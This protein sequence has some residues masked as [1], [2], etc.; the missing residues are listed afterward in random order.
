MRGRFW[1]LL[2]F[3][4]LVQIL[5]NAGV[6]A[7]YL[8]VMATVPIGFATFAAAYDALSRKATTA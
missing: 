5:M 2:V 4:F 6:A 8:G 1:M 7:V 3:S